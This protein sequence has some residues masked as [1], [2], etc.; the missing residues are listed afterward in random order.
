MAH[1]RYE[2]RGQNIR[3]GLAP[4]QKLIWEGAGSPEGA[5]AEARVRFTQAAA[6]MW[7]TGDWTE[8]VLEGPDGMFDRVRYEDK[9][10]DHPHA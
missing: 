8:V 1:R 3:P 9:P 5:G 4:Q 6:Q 10:H 2:V 7:E